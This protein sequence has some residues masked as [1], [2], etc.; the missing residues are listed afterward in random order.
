MTP[1]WYWKRRAIGELRMLAD[2][3]RPTGGSADPERDDVV[4]QQDGN[5]RLAKDH[6]HNA[7]H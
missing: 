4:Q 6:L 1:K 2:K 7:R 3:S 5:D